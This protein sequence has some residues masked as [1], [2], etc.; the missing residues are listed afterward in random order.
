VLQKTDHTASL[1]GGAQK[2]RLPEG[3]AIDRGEL[4]Q[5][6]FDGKTYA[7][8]AGDTLASALLANGVR[9]V[10]RS[11]KYHRPR[12]ILTA[13][14]EEPNALVEL[15]SGDRREPNT[16]ATVAELYDG[17]EASSQHRFPSLKFDLMAV[18]SLL[19][20]IFGAGFYYKTFMWPASFWE[21]VYEPLIRRAAGLGRAAGLPDPD[22]YEKS[23]A[24]CDVLV[25]GG[26]E[27]GIEAALQAARGGQRVLLCDEDYLLGGRGAGESVDLAG[28][29]TELNS[30][31]NLRILPRTTVFG[32]YDGGTYG[33][34]ERVSD[35]VAKPAPGQPRQR[36]WKIIAKRSVL[37]SGATERPLVFG[38]NDRPG[39]MLSGA[40]RRYIR[41]FGVAPGRRA[42]VFVN[43]DEAAGTLAALRDAG[44]AVAALV[45]P[46]PEISAKL[47]QLAAAC[48]AAVYAGGAV[49]RAL[50]RLAVSGVEI[51]PANGKLVKLE[52][53]LLVMSGGWNPALQLTSHLDGKPVWDERIAAFVPGGL[54]P[55]MQVTGAAAGDFANAA[56][57]PL[58]QVRG[59]IGKAFVDFQNDVTA[60][61]VK[62]AKQEGFT[63][64][65]HLKRYTTLGM[66]TDQGKLA[67]VTGIG[68]MAEFTG[69]TIA[70]TGTTRFRPPYTPVAIGALAGAHRGQHFK[71]R[72]LTPTHPWA[73]SQG[74]VF[75]EA[76][77]WLRAQYFPKPGETDWLQTVSR[78]VNTVRSNV[79]ICDVTTLGKIDIQGRDAAKFLE[80]VYT[81]AWENLAV[82]RARY[83]LML[84][85]D[86]FVMD[87]GTTARLAPTHFVMTTTTA[88]AAKVFQHLEFCHQWLWPELAVNFC[89]V[90]DQWAQIAVAGPRSRD[91]LRSIVDPEFDISN[92][93]LPYMGAREV[94]ICGGIRARLFRLSFSG[95][96]AYEI[97]VAARYGNALMEKLMQAG[98]R[99]GIC[100]YGTEALGVMRIEKG[101]PA[102]NELNGQTTAHDLGMA[103][104]LSRKKDFIGRA[105]AARP[106]LTDPARPSLIGLQP[107]NRAD[108]LRA[109]SHL[110]PQGVAATASNDQGYITSAAFSPGLSHW[111]GLGLLS[112][113]PSR[114]GEI[115]RVYD[116]V[117]NG[118]LLAEVVNPVFHDPEGAKLRG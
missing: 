73:K 72:R 77:L 100:P 32:V 1:L 61:D 6:R 64:V 102:G 9:L 12:G 29:I 108:R 8:Y 105:M 21:R 63:S 7:G 55:G 74:A 39:V 86:G 67:N 52:C 4:R 24:F 38:N 17:L 30:F 82:G 2:F 88:N 31:A 15:R 62:L 49:R 25:I 106:A 42:V 79:G 95:E 90:T 14:S 19:S 98:E 92:E 75:I 109:G 46:R 83:G 11:Y 71:P 56:S 20:P 16:K 34:I 84:R 66:A 76:G 57:Q 59:S 43:N 27:A 51:I 96:L 97:A 3:G 80:C 117:R 94:K 99:Y 113:G 22:S 118:D 41:R 37:A 87:D 18:N 58:W 40:V 28:K 78:E 23:T 33:A 36:Y 48:G 44:I 45:D 115:I 54:P 112:N 104:L 26:G 69:K 35:H 70:Q 60:T 103:K 68:L 93:A 114:H 110:L 89:S 10:G 47:R 81:N 91:T 116:P 50:G 53:D 107:V 101:H 65:E 111:I 85:E 5:F 13:G